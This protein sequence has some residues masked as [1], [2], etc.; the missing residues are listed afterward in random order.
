MDQGL[1]RGAAVAAVVLSVFAI[2]AAP[3]HATITP[4]AA[5]F[6]ANS[7]DS[8]FSVAPGVVT[9]CPTSTITGVTSVDG[10]SISAVLDYSGNTGTGATCTWTILGA[11]SP[12]I[13]TCSLRVTL[14]STSSV[15]GSS[16]SFAMEV[17]G[18]NPRDACSID[19]T[20]HLCRI[21]IGPQTSTLFGTFHQATQTISVARALL[22]ATGSGGVC[23]T[24]T[25]TYALTI[26]YRVTTPRITIS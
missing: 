25:R 5:P 1:S 11:S 26:T 7:T 2:A 16:A 3:A 21:T 9:L 12:A 14:R 4:A 8:S 6:S 13:F 24:G 23:G 19:M 20:W 10:R 18:S 22:N 15:A 17:D